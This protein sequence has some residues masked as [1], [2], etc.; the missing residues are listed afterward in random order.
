MKE[1]TFTSICRNNG[2][3]I[4][5]A[6]PAEEM[7][8]G[9]RL[10]EDIFDFCNQIKRP[11]YCTYHPIQSKQMLYAV[12]R[13]VHTECRAGVLF[14]ILHF[15][16]HGDAD[17]GLYIAASTEHVAWAELIGLIAEIN[18]A[19]QN[20]TGVVLASCFGFEIS[21]HVTF[22]APCPFNF[23]V[24]AHAEIKAGQLQDIMLAFYKEPVESGD[25]RG[26]LAALDSRMRAFI[27]AEWFYRTFAT[28][29]VQHFN[30]AGRSAIVEAIV[31]SQV[32]KAG[33]E[34]RELV[35]AARAKARKFVK[36]PQSYF[37]YASRMFLHNKVLVSF[38]DFNAFVEAKRPR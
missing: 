6:L 7:K 32:A 12:L 8:T 31:S 35:R 28:F 13:A 10:H 33:Y 25:L 36:S 24:A 16:C 11:G 19:T 3:I 17:K 18:A 30:H 22:Q 34:S 37:R 9:R 4:L 15:E 20:N 27:C 38:E 23:V 5:D 14:P 21:K 29:M 2:L 26:G 1:L